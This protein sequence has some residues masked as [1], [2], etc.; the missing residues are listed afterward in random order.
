MFHHF[1]D[2]K[3]I[4]TGQGSITSIQFDKIIQYLLSN[5]NVLNPKE[6]IEKSI[7]NSINRND[8]CITFDDSLYCQYKIALKVLNKY[9]L[10]AFWFIYSSV[11]DGILDNLKYIENLEFVILKIL[12]IFFIIFCKNIEILNLKK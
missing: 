9:N 2:K 6:W 11:F 10:K 7:S 1:H 12:M 4:K 5:N 8:V 3:L